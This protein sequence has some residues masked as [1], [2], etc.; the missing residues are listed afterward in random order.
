[1]L[2]GYARVSTTDQEFSN[3]FSELASARFDWHFLLVGKRW[4]FEQ[5]RAKVG[6]LS[7]SNV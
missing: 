2:L 6:S 4:F 5:T 1:M 7:M 3:G